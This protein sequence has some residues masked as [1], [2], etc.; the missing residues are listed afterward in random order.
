MKCWIAESY[1]LCSEH[2]PPT[3]TDASCED[4][5]GVVARASPIGFATE[6]M[7]RSSEDVS[8]RVQYAIGDFYR[9][10]RM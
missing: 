10:F 4:H 9:P 3:H 7:A 8:L 5:L 6:R 2:G 1:A